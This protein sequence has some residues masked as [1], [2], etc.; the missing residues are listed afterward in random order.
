MLE[1]QAKTLG[2][3]VQFVGYKSQSEVA[4]Y[5]KKTDVLVLPSFAE[6]V[7]VVLMEAMA[8]SIPVVTT[9]IAGVPELVEDG[10]S[11]LLVSPGDVDALQAAVS[12]LINNSAK[13]KKMGNAGRK[14]VVAQYNVKTES[15]WLAQI[16]AAY[17]SGE[18]LGLR[19]LDEGK[20]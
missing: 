20:K 8:A 11:G 10:V 13:R 6:G 9:R 14:H 17:E 12:A 2:G 15:A 3:A 1:Q 18:M 7:P 5:L 16:F 19:P 4:E